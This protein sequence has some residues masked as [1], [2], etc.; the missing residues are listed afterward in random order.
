MG[1]NL[2]PVQA[3]HLKLSLD[4]FSRY[5]LGSGFTERV[6]FVLVYYYLLTPSGDSSS[7]VPN[8]LL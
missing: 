5:S 8:F 3:S 7:Q 4:C 2:L 6:V 1:V